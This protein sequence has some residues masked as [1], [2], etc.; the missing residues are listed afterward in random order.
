MAGKIFIGLM[1]VS[2]FLSGC[3]GGGAGPLGIGAIMGDRNLAAAEPLFSKEEQSCV[4][5]A[6]E[7]IGLV[8]AKPAKD[9]DDYDRGDVGNRKKLK[10]KAACAR[11]R[12][13]FE[14]FLPK[15]KADENAPPVYNTM[16]RNEIID[17]MIASSN[18]KCTRYSALLK[19]ADGAMNAGLSVGAI[20]TGGLGSIVGGINTAKALAGTSSILSGSRAALNDTYLSNQTIHVLTAA[21][22]KARRAQ[23]RTITNRQACPIEQYSLMRGIE[24]AFAYHQSCSLVSGLAETAL[25]IERSENPGLAQMRLQFSEIANLRRQ[26]AEFSKDVSITPIASAPSPGSLKKLNAADTALQS[27]ISDLEAALGVEAQAITDLATAK[28][29][30]ATSGGDDQSAE[31]KAVKDKTTE[32]EGARVA[33]LG[34][35]KLRDEAA[36]TRDDEVRALVRTTLQSEIVSE[37]ETRICPFG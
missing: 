33:R 18:R 36:R 35:V 23:R 31:A 7:L 13:N 11:I 9:A 32:V 5:S 2:I 8:F 27:A 3:A 37:P 14:F 22:D 21:F 34:R 24:D 16:Q 19:N 10:H 25:S 4:G 26:A 1:A 12:A 28:A 29:N 17:A 6:D 15:A 20:L 30:L